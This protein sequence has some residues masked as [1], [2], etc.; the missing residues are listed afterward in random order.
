VGHGGRRLA[1]GLIV[2]AIVVLVAAAS[3]SANS[4]SVKQVA[5]GDVPQLRAPVG[6]RQ[7]DS[8]A[9]RSLS[10]GAS[11]AF[12]ILPG[13]PSARG[14]GDI[15][16][17]GFEGSVGHWYLDSDPLGSP[18]WGFWN[19]RPAAGA[20]S[21]YCAGSPI[22]PPGPYA[23]NM[24]AAM[25]TDQI[26]LSGM[27]SAQLDYKLYC[28][29]EPGYDYVSV[30]V[31]ANDFQTLGGWTYSGN[32]WTWTWTGN[33]QGWVDDFIDLADVPGLGSVCGQSNVSIMFLF[34]SDASTVAEGAYVDEVRVSNP[35]KPVVVTMTA[36]PRTVGYNTP[37]SIAG[38]LTNA[39]GTPLP[40]RPVDLYTS[41]DGTGF[42]HHSTL[43]S[44]TGSY[45]SAVRIVRRTCFELRFEGDGEYQAGNSAR[46]WVMARAKLTPPAFGTSVRRGVLVTK[47]GTLLPRHSAAANRQGHTKI[48][49]SRYSNGKYRLVYRY[50]AQSYRNT[51]SAT[52]YSVRFRWPVA[53]KWRVRAIHEDPDHA[54]TT[55]SW[56]Y[57]RV[58]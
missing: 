35:P 34:E 32:S 31:S 15:F 1:V 58:L 29:T 38:S 47:W 11:R 54:K 23:N 19:S 51:T 26:D 16:Y 42:D 36:S 10:A 6:L 50:R 45:A 55:S 57:F 4:L 8:G 43:S 13:S 53:S 12:P 25:W 40:N 33:T 37:V 30:L 27:T 41:L 3:A 17:D 20:W 22:K 9:L 14:A 46:H 44:V 21:A 5:T 2:A 28:V 18:T 39:S 56:R 52:K 49:F 7:L 24:F 48:E